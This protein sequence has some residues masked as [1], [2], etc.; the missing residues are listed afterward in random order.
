MAKRMLPLL[1]ALALAGA[2][3]V[4]EAC[5]IV[6]VSAIP[7]S[8]MSHAASGHG[9]S[10]HEHGP[11]PG[12]RLAAAPHACEHDSE[13]PAPPGVFAAQ[14]TTVAAPLAVLVTPADVLAPLPILFF[15]TG[16]GA[17]HVP[18]AGIAL[19]APLRI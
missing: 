18:A 1:V 8:S 16:A 4:F 7:S 17:R 2:P 5:Q 11:T 9:K 15:I 3:V 14:D 10:C 12:P 19:A 13:Q 6:C